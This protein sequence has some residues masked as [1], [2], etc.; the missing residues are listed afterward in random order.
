MKVVSH[1]TSDVL[2]AFFV[3]GN[4]ERLADDVILHRIHEL[5]PIETKVAVGLKI[6]PAF[7]AL[8]V[9]F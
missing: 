2:D 7:E 9:P 1:F 8:F 4:E 3:I 6:L 5:I